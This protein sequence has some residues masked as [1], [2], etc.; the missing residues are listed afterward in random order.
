ME[1]DQRKKQKADDKITSN[2]A[3]R[4]DLLPPDARLCT[5]N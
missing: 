2:A 5:Q 1:E 3:G 4:A